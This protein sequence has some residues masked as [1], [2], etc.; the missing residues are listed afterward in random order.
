MERKYFQGSWCIET[1]AWMYPSPSIAMDGW[2]WPLSS[3]YSA[4][5]PVASR[6]QPEVHVPSAA[7]TARFTWCFAATEP[8]TL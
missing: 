7:R 5:A 1:N 8:G 6:R 3:R 2:L 4:Q